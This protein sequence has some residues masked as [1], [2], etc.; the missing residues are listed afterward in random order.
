MS[1]RERLRSRFARRT[2]QRLTGE[3]PSAWRLVGGLALLVAVGTV[4]LLLPG[5]GATDRLTIGEAAFTAT[6]A[7]SVTGLSVI[8]PATDLTLFGQIILMILIQL[9]G[10]GFMA[11]TVLTFWLLRRK[12][13]LADRIALQ[14]LAW[15]GAAARDPENRWPFA[16]G[17]LG[18]RGPGR[19][20]AVV[21]LASPV[22]RRTCAVL[23]PIPCSVGL[24]QR[25]LRPVHRPAGLSCRH[26]ARPDDHGDLERA[27]R[28]RRSGH[29][30]VGRPVLA[31]RP[32]HV[33][34]PADPDGVIRA[35]RPGRDRHLSW[36]NDRLVGSWQQSPG[37][38]GYRARSFSPS[39]PAPPASR[40]CRALPRSRRLPNGSSAA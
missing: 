28:C 5:V 30:R 6:S 25:R 21:A 8:T 18:H 4:L 35:D 38:S 9:G 31:S 24:L 33:A 22:G 12:V 26:P 34:Q 16:V 37:P 36:P 13:S 19:A 32:A 3:T 7:S 17:G 29:S 10:V 20:G 40:C 23:R 2:S 1:L 14:E 11:L 27:D 39:P 15:T